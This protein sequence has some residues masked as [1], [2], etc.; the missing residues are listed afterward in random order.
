MSTFQSTLSVLGLLERRARNH[1]IQCIAGIAEGPLFSVIPRT[2]GRFSS[3]EQRPL[4]REIVR[5][6]ALIDD[7]FCNRF[8]DVYDQQ[9]C[10]LNNVSHKLRDRRRHGWLKSALKAQ[11]NPIVRLNKVDVP[12][13][14]LAA[15][16]S[17]MYFHWLLDVL[18]RIYVAREAGIECGRWLYVSKAAPFQKES[19]EAL[20]VLE[21]T[22]DCDEKVIIHAN[23]IA[24][25]VHQIAVGHLPPA[26][27]VRYLRTEL[28][29]KLGA[30]RPCFGKRLYVSRNDAGRRNIIGEEDLIDALS[31]IGFEKIVPGEL[32]VRDQAAAFANAE[33]IVG[34]HGSS[35]ANLVFC[36]PRTK[37]LELFPHNYF[38]EGPYRLA[39]AVDLDYF[40]ARA[41]KVYRKGLPIETDYGVSTDDVFDTLRLAGVKT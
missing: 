16:T 9:G 37:V 23:D 39:Q 20:G 10:R 35:F 13:L 22:I 15:S 11:R 3:W 30:A 41:R 28:L 2:G 12:I 24:T 18:P 26:W 8:G 40:Y 14:N 17:H 19:L 38:D 36:Q 29:G 25:P 31:V 5:G 21:R 34:A 32:S 1:E 27:A 6:V 7:G 4:R 33:V